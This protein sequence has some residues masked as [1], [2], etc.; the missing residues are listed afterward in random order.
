M[1]KE[2]LESQ[3]LALEERVAFAERDRDAAFATLRDEGKHLRD[4][5]KRSGHVIAGMRRTFDTA[6]KALTADPPRT[7]E[8]LVII[9]ST[10]DATGNGVEE[11]VPLLPDERIALQKLLYMIDTIGEPIATGAGNIVWFSPDHDESKDVHRSDLQD[12]KSAI[13]RILGG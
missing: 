6:Q 12:A 4:K 2:A 9:Q 8:A 1:T 3:V 7:T 5:L 13:S 11:L 10:L